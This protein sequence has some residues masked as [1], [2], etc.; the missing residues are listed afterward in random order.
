MWLICPCQI[1]FEL[2]IERVF[3]YHVSMELRGTAATGVVEPT[4]TELALDTLSTSL[5]H[6]V[7]I[8]EDGGLD[9]FND[10]AL[11]GFLQDF[12][13][14][15]NRLPLIDHRV[16]GDATRRGLPD[17][18]CQG[19]MARALASALRI[20]MPEAT[21]RVHAA[22][23]V[24]ERTSMLG[25]P[26]DPVRPHLAAAQRAGEIGTEHVSI[27]ERALVKVDRAG[28]DPAAIDAG[29]ELLTRFAHQFGPKDLKRLADQVVD[30]I[31]PDGTLPDDQLNADRRFLHLRQTKDG[32]YAGEFRLTAECGAKLQTLLGPLA[33]PRLN[34]TTGPDGRLI[35]EP[36]SRH[37]VQR[38]HDA[39]E[40]IC[41]RLLRSSNPVPD[42]GG[43]PATV[44]ITIDVDDLLA[45]TGYGIA[46]D[47]TLI[48]TE[49]VRELADSADVYTAFLNNRGEVLRLGRTRRI[50]SR[51]QTIALTARDG[52]CSFPGCD[53]APDWCERHHVVSWIDG[54]STDLDNL[55][56]LC[57]YHHHNFAGKGWE[58][59]MNADGIPEWT[60]PWWI[61]QARTPLINTRICGT[62]A[63][64]QH[65]RQ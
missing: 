43:T 1:Q 54:G 5:D 50:A 56:L 16:I 27:I 63:A 55:T 33:K 49:R 45:N 38:M 51:G 44:I 59:E 20:S 61:D 18:L 29:E 64:R 40:D 48:R 15:R 8:V 17:T 10:A 57:R 34:T 31:N 21:R 24:G 53:T 26:I 2:A 52:G 12:E 41:D 62:L 22:E 47:G 7:K 42:S 4:P 65:R 58:C 6:L 23:A 11:V 13:R 30:A 36:D 14:V 25:Q 60:P 28:F 9:A 35:E 3:E 37:H 19:S 46:S 39:L 32:A